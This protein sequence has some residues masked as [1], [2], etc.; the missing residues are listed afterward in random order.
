MISMK[1]LSFLLVA[2]TIVVVSCDKDKFTT[3]PQL[4]INSISP[5]TVNSGDIVQ[6]RGRYT[7]Q[8]GDIDSALFVYKWYNGTTAILPFDTL[9][10]SFDA[11]GLPTNVKEAEITVAFQY[12]TTDPNGYITLPGLTERDTTATLGLI[13]IDKEGNRSDYG[14]SDQIRI[15]KP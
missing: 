5:N 15:I 7:D 3:V 10:Y 8:E 4:E 9:R 6:L 11:L 14:E 13:I 2:L 1:L 12:N